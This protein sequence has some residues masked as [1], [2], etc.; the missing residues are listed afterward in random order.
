MTKLKRDLEFKSNGIY[1]VNLSNLIFKCFKVLSL[2]YHRLTFESM[3][4]REYQGD[5]VT[6]NECEKTVSAYLAC[7]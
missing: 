2:I 3:E 7:L 5:R 6:F 1:I 4:L